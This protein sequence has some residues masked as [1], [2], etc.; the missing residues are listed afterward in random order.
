MAKRDTTGMSAN[1][2]GSMVMPLMIL[3]DFPGLTAEMYDAFVIELGLD[4]EPAAGLIV[5]ITGDHNGTWREVNVWESGDAYEAFMRDRVG[6]IIE[7]WASQGAELPPMPE[8]QFMET[9]KLT[10]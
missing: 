7:R 6:P 5:H 10:R 4:D 2:N 8:P 3:K 9:Y 1:G